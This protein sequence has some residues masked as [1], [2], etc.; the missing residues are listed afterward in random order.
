LGFDRIAKGWV[1]GIT[2]DSQ[3]EQSYPEDVFR[4]LLAVERTRSERS[5]RPFALLLVDL[6]PDARGSSA[7]L[8]PL[9]ARKILASLQQCLRE[10]DYMGWYRADAVVGAVLTELPDG[11]D[12]VAPNSV[13][14]RANRVLSQNLPPRIATRIRLRLHLYG[15]P[16]AASAYHHTRGQG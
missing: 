9:V 14:A 7:L 12:V 6:K 8:H 16:Q 3:L 5:G 15:A 10:T 13:A 2:R 4:H 1:P 11:P